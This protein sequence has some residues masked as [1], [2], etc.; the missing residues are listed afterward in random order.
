LITEINATDSEM[1]VTGTYYD[2]DQGYVTVSTPEPLLVSTEDWPILGALLCIGDKNTKARLTAINDYSY[3]IEADTNGDNVYNYDSGVLIWPGAPLPSPWQQKASMPTP[4]SD[5]G[6][7]AIG[8][9][10]YVIGGYPGLGAGPT[11]V[12]EEY[13]PLLNLWSTKSPIPSERQNFGIGVVNDKIYV[14]GG[15]TGIAPNTGQTNIVEEYNAILNSWITKSPMPTARSDFAVAVSNGKV[16][17]IGGMAPDSMEE[18]DPVTDSWT[19]KASMPTP[20]YSLSVSVFN[21]KI[22]AI[23]GIGAAGVLDIVEEYDPNTNMWASK[24][25]M[26]TKRADLVSVTVGENIYAIGGRG[27][28]VVERYNPTTNSW[29]SK[30]NMPQPCYSKCAASVVNDKIYVFGVWINY[31]QVYEYDPTV[32]P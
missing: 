29:V 7:G 24:A 17:A 28:G 1:E 9:K 3:R 30:A 11:N 26:P 2:P 32:D 27:S 4:R 22:Y 8:S 6:S 10:V 21:G 18:Y 14:I 19:S 25:T 15:I 20:R 16:Y 12:N 23:G 5:L 13:D 31:S